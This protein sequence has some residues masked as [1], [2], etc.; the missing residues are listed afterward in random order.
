MCQFVESIPT[1]Q[2]TQCEFFNPTSFFFFEQIFKKLNGQ[3][4]CSF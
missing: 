3:I 1:Q 2:N 4:N